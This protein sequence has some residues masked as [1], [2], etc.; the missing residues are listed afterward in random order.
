[1]SSYLE[2]LEPGPIRDENSL[3]DGEENDINTNSKFRLENLGQFL[4]C[5]EKSLMT[6]RGEIPLASALMS[7]IVTTI[8]RNTFE[9]YE[10]DHSWAE[11][12]LLIHHVSDAKFVKTNGPL[13]LYGI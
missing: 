3:T 2:D 4:M 6:E 8:P 10:L 11:N 5:S 12:K 7:G 13:F 1:V 9:C